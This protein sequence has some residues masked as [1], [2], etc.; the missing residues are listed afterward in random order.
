MS[1]AI[2]ADSRW[3]GRR[4]RRVEDRLHGRQLRWLND[5]PF[6]L[7][8]LRRVAFA[9]HRARVDVVLPAIEAE[10]AVDALR[11]HGWRHEATGTA[12]DEGE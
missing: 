6:M 2:V 5:L 8:R 11:R 12:G 9:H 3:V 7:A 1:A 10:M 4:L